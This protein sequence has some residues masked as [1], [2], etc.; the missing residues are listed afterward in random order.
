M[1][2]PIGKL[3]GFSGT[4]KQLAHNSGMREASEVNIGK[5]RR[6]AITHHA[7]EDV[8]EGVIEEHFREKKNSKEIWEKVSLKK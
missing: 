7:Y 6:L 3:A 1:K 8:D 2:F 4:I 5:G